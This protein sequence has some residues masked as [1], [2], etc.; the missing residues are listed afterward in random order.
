MKTIRLQLRFLLPLLAILLTAAFVA[1][2]L[3]DSLTLRWF[4]RDLNIRGELVANTL[5]DSIL[6]ASVE[7]KSGKLQ[8]LFD[9]AAQDERLVAIGLC[10]TDGLFLLKTPAC[11][12]RPKTEPLMR[13]VPI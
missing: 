12:R 2:P 13:G 6:D 7:G 1:L 10:S 9:R 4:A 11:W 5:S 3:M 8:A